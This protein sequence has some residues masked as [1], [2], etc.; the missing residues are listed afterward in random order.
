M[1]PLRLLAAEV[2]PKTCPC[3][4]FWLEPPPTAGCWSPVGQPSG[5]PEPPCAPH[6]ARIGPVSTANVP[7]VGDD[8]TM[9]RSKYCSV[10]V[11]PPAVQ[12]VAALV[13]V[14]RADAFE[15]VDQYV[16]IAPESTIAA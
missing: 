1:L 9:P 10:P 12:G 14:P 16:P 2:D 6:A 7:V 3:W 13:G 11:T 8:S 15:P 4:K 5:P